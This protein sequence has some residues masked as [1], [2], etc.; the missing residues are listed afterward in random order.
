VA[1]FAAYHPLWFTRVC[2]PAVASVLDA[3]PTVLAWMDRMAAI[4]HGQVGKATSAEAIALAA[5]AEPAALS[6]EAFQDDHGIP[7]GSL[8]T[9]AAETFGQE[10]TEGELVAATRTRYT[11]RRTDA[12]VGTV[13]VHFP[14]IGYVLKKV[15]A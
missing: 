4:G 8:V 3:T 15:V 5:A 10:P 1:D 6:A 7:L 11:L 14:R 13:H 12:R 2:V 9:L